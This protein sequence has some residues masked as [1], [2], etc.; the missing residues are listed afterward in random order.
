MRMR[1][2]ALPFLFVTASAQAQEQPKPGRSEEIVVQGNR[3]L[4]RQVQ[5][6]VD[7]LTPA[8]AGGQIGRFDSK[9]CPAALGLPDYQNRAI[10]DRVRSVA[11]AAGLKV[12]GSGC[13]PNALLIVAADKNGFIT[14]LYKTRPQL[15]H[16]PNGWPRRPV[17][18]SEPVAAWQVEGTLDA[19]GIPVSDAVRG[20]RPVGYKMVVS[21][22]SSR[23]RPASRPYF[24]AGVVV[25]EMK[26][27]AGITTTQ[28]ADYAAMRLFTRADPE[29][30]KASTVPTILK[31]LDTPTGGSAPIT[32]TAWDMSFLKGLYSSEARQ[33]AN[34]QRSQ[35][36]HKMKRDMAQGNGPQDQ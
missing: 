33:Y 10:V 20:G 35:I 9:V 12:A 4:D 13:Q 18:T 8:P 25:V 28:L 17:L 11:V 21:T 14:A 19:D 24:M 29:E 30:V 1:R 26:A 15:F 6:F 2:L 27:L 23:L 3:D 32:L 5:Q 34:R 22:D 16:D 7:A 31:L 36:Q